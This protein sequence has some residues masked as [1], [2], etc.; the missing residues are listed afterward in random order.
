MIPG[1]Y[2]GRGKMFYMA[3]Y[4]Q[5]R[6]PNTF[7]RERT[8]LNPAALEG[9]FLYNVGSE[10]RS[11]NLLQLAAANGQISTTDPLVM[12]LLNKIQAAARTEG[13]ISQNSDPLL[14]TFAWQSPGELFEHQP[15][16]RVDYNATEKHRL[17]GSYATI[18]AK[19]DPDYLNSADARFPGA[20]VYRLFTS[21]RPLCTASLMGRW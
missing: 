19:R 10:T 8:I 3:H 20:P 1:L 4:E 11:V 21:T 18:W 9:N 15:T 5:L 2:D 14:Q 16:I 12:G 7:T 6:F 13:T 17:S